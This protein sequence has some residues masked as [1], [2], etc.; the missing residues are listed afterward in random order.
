MD[1]SHNRRSQP[2]GFQENSIGCNAAITYIRCSIAL[3][4]ISEA[5]HLPRVR[6]EFRVC[7]E[8]QT[9][10]LSIEVIQAACLESVRIQRIWRGVFLQSQ[11][12]AIKVNNVCVGCGAD[13]ECHGIGEFVA[14][15]TYHKD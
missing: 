4:F 15:F 9:G 5:D 8:G 14:I 3:G 10:Q 12:S 11:Q 2:H 1:H 13:L 7:G 6:I